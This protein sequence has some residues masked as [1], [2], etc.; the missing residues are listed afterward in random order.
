MIPASV[1]NSHNAILRREGAATSYRVQSFETWVAG[2]A[3]Q[4]VRCC[5]TSCRRPTIELQWRIRRYELQR[6]IDPQPSPLAVYHRRAEQAIFFESRLR[7]E[8]RIGIKI[9]IA[10]YP[11]VARRYYGN[12][13]RGIPVRSG[14]RGRFRRLNSPCGSSLRYSQSSISSRTRTTPWTLRQSAR[15]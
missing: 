1:L 11:K 2:C 14:L 8:D 12:G 4:S 6:R 9:D 13:A 3:H 5:L 15:S 10:P 7:N